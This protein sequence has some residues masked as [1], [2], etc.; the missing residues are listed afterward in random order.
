MKRK[1]ALLI[2]AIVVVAICAFLFVR[3]KYLT[4]P[5]N[6]EV[7][8]FLEKF[9]TSVISGEPESVLHFFDVQKPS[10]ALLKLVNVLCN[11]AQA[12]QDAPGVL[13]S[14][15]T[16]YADIKIINNE[17]IEVNVPA[18]FKPAESSNNQQP[19]E[20]H[21]LIKIR[22]T[23]PGEFKVIQ[24]DGRGFFKDYVA[25]ERKIG[26]SKDTTP[27]YYSPIT[28]AAFKTA[29]KLK[30]RYDSVLY[31]EHIDN[32]TFFYVAKG[33][34]RD[35]SVPYRQSK[36]TDSYKQGLVNPELKE[37]I[38]VEYDVIHNIGG[39]IDNLIEV[40]KA[41]KKGLFDINGKIIVPAEYNEILPL[42]QGETNLA[43]LR[44]DDDYFYLSPNLSVSEKISGF[45]IA[46]VLPKI[47]SF[48]TSYTLSDST[49]KNIM[50]DNARDSFTST[51][52]SPSY[53]VNWGILPK[54]LVFRN[55]LRK[56]G[57][58]PDEMEEEEGSG[59][60]QITFDGYTEKGSNWLASAFY[61]LVD[62][63]LGGRGGLYES[64]NVLLV[65]KNKNRILSYNAQ[66][67][68]GGG[69]GGQPVSGRCNN[70]YL[71]AINDT[72]FEYRTTCRADQLLHDNSSL[73]EAP[74]YYYLHIKNGKLEALPDKLLFS[75]T[76]YIR[77]NDTYLG[78]CYMIDDKPVDH[79][80]YEILRYMKNEI[81]A[82]YNY[83]FKDTL[84]T[85]VFQQRF[86]ISDDD[87]K[88]VNVNDSLNAIEKYNINFIEQK[89]KAMKAPPKVLAAK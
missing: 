71:R 6:T 36:D 25:Y 37:I 19:F 74:H 44:K 57:N 17:L 56:P 21:L 18:D 70:D 87:K 35:R 33:H 62:D 14:L 81:Y 45:K 16:A 4:K 13:V 2:A 53:L 48:N 58:N 27:P 28:L 55:P 82:Q 1:P 69:E 42:E 34:F 73:D 52:I 9:N 31:F 65:D 43:I 68:F 3:G 40:E 79:T 23:G 78:G 41:D 32:K 80:T 60:Y 77:M 89:L 64:K 85:K 76:K 86:Y 88:L 15:N 11:K 49:S 67:Y 66:T 29:E 50:E 5:K 26:V 22:K 39:T 7:Y 46:D 63:Y 83:T 59:Y 51:I 47:K 61:S 38:P 72:L 12:G 20:S 24:I 30:G 75:F 54:L 8:T 10:K 84:W